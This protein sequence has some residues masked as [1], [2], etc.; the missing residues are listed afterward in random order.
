MAQ[1]THA[2]L[3]AALQAQTRLPVPSVLALRVAV[4]LATWSMRRRTRKQLADLDDHLL[5]DIGLDRPAAHR[6]ARRMFWQG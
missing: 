1:T 4:V 6:E 5:H 3:L 2:P